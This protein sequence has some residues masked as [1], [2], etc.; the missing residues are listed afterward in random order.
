MLAGTW[1]PYPSCWR[2]GQLDWKMPSSFENWS[3]LLC[4]F[5]SWVSLT[6]GDLVLAPARTGPYEG[7]APLEPFLHSSTLFVSSSFKGVAFVVSAVELKEF[8]GG[9]YE[10]AL[11][12]IVLFALVWWFSSRPR[13]RMAVTGLFAL[14]Y[15]SFRFFV[16][17]FREPDLHLGFVA[18]EW[19]TMGQVLSTPM[20]LGGLLLLALAYS[21]PQGQLKSL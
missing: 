3:C 19:L 10:V 14:G 4:P 7:Q 15:G 21:R 8:D 13:P 11:E 1:L 12:G 16:E 2:F 5:C 6:E 17:F 9:D 18:F 20:I